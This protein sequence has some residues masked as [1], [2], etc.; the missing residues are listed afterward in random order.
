MALNIYVQLGRYPLKRHPIGPA[1]KRSK[2]PDEAAD[3]HRERHDGSPQPE[4]FE[5][6]FERLRLVRV[7]VAGRRLGLA[8]SEPLARFR[9][10]W[11]IGGSIP[12]GP[13]FA[14]RPFRVRLSV[15]RSPAARALVARIFLALRWFGVDAT[16]RRQ[17]VVDHGRSRPGIRPYEAICR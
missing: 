2:R 17:R 12:V 9:I 16:R 15:A 11:R 10:G 3:D 6:V 13:R 5:P 14:G 7:V 1:R 4:P 8:V